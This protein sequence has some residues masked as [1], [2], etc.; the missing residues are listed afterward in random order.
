MLPRHYGK[1]VKLMRRGQLDSD[2]AIVG[3]GQCVMQVA[4]QRGKKIFSR[5]QKPME[6]PLTEGD[7]IGHMLRGSDGQFE[8]AQANIRSAT[9]CLLWT[10][11]QDAFE[12]IERL[13]KKRVQDRMEK[14]LKASAALLKS[15]Q[16]HTIHAIAAE[17]EQKHYSCDAVVAPTAGQPSFFFVME[18]EF[19]V[20]GE[21][22]SKEHGSPRKAGECHPALAPASTMHM[23]PHMVI[24]LGASH[25]GYTCAASRAQNLSR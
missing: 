10:L 25:G 2:F 19:A 18:G 23:P 13:F 7:P 21:K 11:S 6:V 1:D 9:D 17:L 3:R 4:Q 20:I 5:N 14:F 15:T 8:G 24:T 16:P 22:S 12:Q